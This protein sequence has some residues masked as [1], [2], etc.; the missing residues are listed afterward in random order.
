KRYHQVFYEMED[1][2]QEEPSG[3]KYGGVYVIVGGSGTIGQILKRYLISDYEAQVVWIGRTPEEDQLIQE[4]M[5]SCKGRD[6]SISYI[7][8]DVMDEIQMERAVKR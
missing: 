1:L 4:K 8:A 2:N 5:E 3:I 6:G 7:Q